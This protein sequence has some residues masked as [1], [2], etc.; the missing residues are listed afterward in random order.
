MMDFEEAISRLQAA[1]GN[2]EKLTLATVDIVLATHEPALRTALEAAAVPHW[3]DARIL[4]ALL[5][6]NEAVASK[7]VEELRQLPMVEAFPAHDAWNVH[8]ATRLALRRRLASEE[9][10]RLHALSAL[11]AKCFENDGPASR[12]ETI[13]H[14][15][16]AAPEQAADELERLWKE[17]N[18]AG[19]YEPLQA[20][21]VALGELILAD[22]LTPSARARSL[23]CFGLIRSGMLPLRKAKE[24][25]REALK[26]FHNLG[27][28]SG[29]ADARNQLGNILRAEGNLA[30]ALREYEA[31][32]QI[33]ERLTQCDPDNTDWQR[34]LSVSHNC[35]GR[36]YEAQG[37]LAEALREYEASKQIRGR[38]TQRDPDNTGWQ[39]DLSFSHNRIGGVYQTQ[40]R[41]A[42]AL[43]EYEADKQ[44]MERLTQRDPENTDWQHGLSVSH[45]CVGSVYEAQGR[46]ADALREYEADLAIAD[47]LAAHDPT[48]AHWQKDLATAQMSV[49]R[50]RKQ[51]GPQP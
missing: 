14:R 27:H 51:L 36:V 32:K 49:D 11:A 42:N 9:V 43:R 26:L 39:R 41:L 20:L 7:W 35:V 6:T 44:I 46:L 16:L 3:F 37:R 10:S 31:Y 22:Q 1:Q 8:E 34:E 38:L 5:E 45:N 19:H 23:V 13:Y 15:L 28:E 4:S 50:L 30:G 24:L 2:P 21:S 18:G 17:W 47:R 29:E 48:N 33:M 40:G 25:S 12:V